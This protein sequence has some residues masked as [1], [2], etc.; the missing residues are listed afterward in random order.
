V[1]SCARLSAS[2]ENR[3]AI[4][5]GPNQLAGKQDISRL[6][7][8]V[9]KLAVTDSF[10]GNSYANDPRTTFL[11]WNIYGGGS[12][13][14]TMDKLSYTWGGLIE[15]NQ[16][17]WAVRTGYFLVPDVSNSNHFDRHIPGRGEYVAELELRYS[18]AAPPGKLRFFGWV[19]RGNMGQYSAAVALPVTT[20]DYP[21]IA[22]TRAVRTNYGFVVSAEQAVTGDLGVFSRASWS[23][24]RV[25]VLGWTDCDDS[26]SLGAVLKGTSWGRPNDKI[27]VAGL[28]EGLSPEARA[29]FAAG[30]LGILIGDG[31]LNYR[32]ENVL[33]AYYAYSVNKWATLTIGS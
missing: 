11:N 23:P 33:E 29:Y 19:N 1:R 15:L 24:G 21:D 22:L 13:D 6:T 10:D 8:T 32:Q 17:F 14:W 30:G 2:A 28:T 16:Q 12:Y 26:L 9:G 25:E 5:E 27:G 20:P 4:E 31:Q 18:L 7:V 3:E